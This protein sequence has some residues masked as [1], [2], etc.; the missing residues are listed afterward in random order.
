MLE[1]LSKLERIEAKVEAKYRGNDDLD[2]RVVGADEF[3][4]KN[5]T[6]WATT[7]NERAKR[8]TRG[9]LMNLP[10][11][12]MT[13]YTLEEIGDD[14]IKNLNENCISVDGQPST[15]NGQNTRLDATME[16]TMTFQRGYLVVILPKTQSETLFDKLSRY[17]HMVALETCSKNGH[18]IVYKKQRNQ[19][20]K[21]E[22]QKQ[23]SIDGTA[24]IWVTAIIKE[25][26]N[27][28]YP[29]NAPDEAGNLQQASSQINPQF[30]QFDHHTF[31]NITE[32]GC[33]EIITHEVGSDDDRYY[34]NEDLSKSFT[35][36]TTKGT[37]LAQ[38]VTEALAS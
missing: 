30:L 22:V 31:A 20:W 27:V 15:V 8:M 21:E 10:T 33:I 17:P 16:S 19:A 7:P 2:D 36:A 11:N 32:F 4:Q 24:R 5:A 25:N 28:E 29:T 34:T 18:H 38:L 14:T 1:I 23:K 26:G 3:I 35:F 12:F 37:S 13:F 9:G 6:W